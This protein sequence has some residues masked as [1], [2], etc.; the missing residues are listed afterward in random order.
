MERFKISI[1]E[2]EFAFPLIQ[3][4]MGVGISL[5]GLASAVAI[6]GGVG[7]VA[8]AG[9]GMTEMLSFG[10]RASK[11]DPMALEV[12]IMKAKE[13][14]PGGVIGAN[15]MTAMC[16]YDDLVR[17]AIEAR[18]DLIISGAGLPLNLP[19]IKS[20]YPASATALVPIVSSAKAAS[21]ITRRWQR[22]YNYTPDAFVVEGPLAGGHLG[23]KLN[24][25]DDPDYS[26]EK[27]VPEV[28]SALEPLG[29]IPV[30][31]A[32]GIWDGHDAARF[33]RMGAAGVQM[34]TRFVATEECDAAR[35]FKESY[36]RA[37][38]TVIISSPVGMPARAITNPFLT[39]MEAGERRPVRCP[40]HCIITC[41]P[42]K[43]PY[44]IADAL[45]TSKL[46]NT[47]D[48]LIFAG[49]N[50]GRVNEIATV[51]DIMNGIAETLEDAKLGVV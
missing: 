36:I 1:G 25:I 22:D 9:I 50:V 41:D 44:C 20:D 27:I 3:G 46:G 42:K 2:H 17:S 14:A 28:I 4:G 45:V 18:A 21:L 34:A 15:I 13:L 11:A 7:V 43:T 39:A 32:G 49:A 29:R 35:E 38:E 10:T 48:G 6:A 24:E 19:G 33:M 5:S 23:F 26:L 31:A 40:Y 16:Y 37:R 30:F 12:E 51:P 8:A 47:T